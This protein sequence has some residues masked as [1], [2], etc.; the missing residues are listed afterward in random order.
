MW[1]QN[2]IFSDQPPHLLKLYTSLSFNLGPPLAQKPWDKIL[3]NTNIF[4]PEYA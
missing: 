3:Q 2:L 4:G 1:G